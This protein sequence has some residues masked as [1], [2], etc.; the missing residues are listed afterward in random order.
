MA[1]GSRKRVGDFCVGDRI[2]A[3]KIKGTID[4]FPSR[5]VAIVRVDNGDMVE[6][7]TRDLGRDEEN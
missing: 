7:S 2:V 1:K 3:R 4:S 6:V 5:R